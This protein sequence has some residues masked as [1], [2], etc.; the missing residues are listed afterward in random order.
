[1]PR[2]TV[3]ERLLN[4]IEI[5]T[6]SGCWIW[7]QHLNAYGY[8]AITVDK[9]VVGAHRVAYQE[10]IGSIPESMCVCHECDI[11]AC[12]NPNHLFLGTHADNM[13]DKADKGRISGI[14]NP[15]SK[16]RK[17]LKQKHT[18]RRADNIGA[19]TPEEL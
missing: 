15:R 17:A 4:S 19:E 8:G 13:K 18:L 14:K 9:K 2:K 12:I 1:M 16:H 7:L 11:P 5:I 10:F 3:K 6:E